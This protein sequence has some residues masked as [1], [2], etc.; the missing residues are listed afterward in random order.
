[1]QDKSPSCNSGIVST[2][3]LELNALWIK[4][5]ITVTHVAK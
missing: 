4:P 1:M 2:A 5:V 3:I